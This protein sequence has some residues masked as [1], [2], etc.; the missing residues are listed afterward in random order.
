MGGGIDKVGAKPI[1]TPKPATVEKAKVDAPKAKAEPA[2]PKPADTFKPT[3]KQAKERAE[4]MK[5]V[6]GTLKFAE[7]PADVQAKFMDRLKKLPPKEFD[8]EVALMA[9][10]ASGP[11]ADRAISTQAKLLEMSQA[12]PEAK[13]RLTP[14]VRSALVDSVGTPRNLARLGSADPVGV[15]GVM[16]QQQAEQAAKALVA[17]PAEQYAQTTDLLA[18]AGTGNPVSPAADPQTEK[19]LVL[20]A[21]AARADR[22]GANL[23]DDAAVKNGSAS[24]TEASRAMKEISDF[25]ADIRGKGKGELIKT[26]SPLDLDPS[27]NDSTLDPNQV[28]DPNADRQGDNDGLYQRYLQSCGPTVAQMARAEADPVYARALA[29]DPSLA[30]KDQADL[31]TKAGANGPRHRE[32]RQMWDDTLA[33]GKRMGMSESTYDRMGAYI[34]GKDQN[35]IDTALAKGT[36]DALRNN[37]NGHPTDAEISKMRADG[38][39]KDTQ[40]KLDVALN[41]AASPST[42]VEYKSKKV[43]G[44]G[45]PSNEDLSN[46]DSNLK[47]GQNVPMRMDIAGEGGTGHFVNITD[48]RGSEPNRRYLVSDPWSG[49]T[50]WVKEGELKNDPGATPHWQKRLFGLDPT[51]VT[52]FYLKKD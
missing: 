2:K 30:D 34:Q 38:K 14:E 19:S 15:A 32:S 33:A 20:K 49:K 10:H 44:S 26:T 29:K 18:R 24:A 35:W 7:V 22:L 48:V 1:A 17:M 8:A 52:D 21:V 4:A 6:E 3:P 31:L 41:S 37:N 11:N 27:T 39:D 51:R 50:G 46:V 42:H 23:Q 5:H 47:R 9:K 16:G 28:R 40:M 45:G 43:T 36:L 25:G 12:S 13:A